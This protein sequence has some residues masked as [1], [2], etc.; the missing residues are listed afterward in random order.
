MQTIKVS[1]ENFFSVFNWMSGFKTLIKIWNRWTNLYNVSPCA[2]YVL[3]KQ[4]SGWTV[5]SELGF[6]VAE[7]LR[8]PTSITRKCELVSKLGSMIL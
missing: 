4:K 7:N 1:W 6:L 3:T 2:S 8:R 5:L